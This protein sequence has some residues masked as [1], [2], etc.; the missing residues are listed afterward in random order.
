M[1][2]TRRALLRTSV[3]L[4][5]AGAVTAFGVEA[6]AANEN[7]LRVT[8]HRVP[9][10]ELSRRLRVVQLT[11]IHVGSAVPEPYLRRVAE[12]TWRAKP[13][14]VVLTG[15]YLNHSLAYARELRHLAG[16]LP[17]PC[18]ATLGNH[19]YYSGRDGVIE[20]LHGG[21]AEVLIN[22]SV[23][24]S[25]GGAE[26]T[27]VGV[28]DGFTRHDNVPRAFDKVRHPDRALVLSH[29]PNTA[30]RIAELDARLVL[31]GHTHGGQIIV[32]GVTTLMQRALGN[33]YVAGWFELDRARLYVSAGVG[34]SII[35]YRAGEAGMPEVAIFDLLPGLVG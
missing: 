21:G 16:L 22:D 33:K 23:V 30:D 13:D 32:P 20:A 12:L 11:D 14:L 9:W 8:R 3:G 5:A 29:F 18:V 10:P 4:A 7:Q 6:R 31:S 34:G 26:L 2:L 15:D 35:A 25:R 17:K 24:L 27:I 1:A 19:D 28:D